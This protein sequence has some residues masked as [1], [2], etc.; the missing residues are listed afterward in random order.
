MKHDRI[1]WLAIVT[2]PESSVTLIRRRYESASTIAQPQRGHP[3]QRNALPRRCRGAPPWVV[4]QGLRRE[5]QKLT[6]GAPGS[7]AAGGPTMEGENHGW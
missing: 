6:A 3:E 2:H 1:K 7:G 4:A 5:L